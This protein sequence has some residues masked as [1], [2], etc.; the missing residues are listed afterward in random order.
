MFNTIKR[1]FNKINDFDVVDVESYSKRLSGFDR[2]VTF[3][4]R[5]KRIR[6]GK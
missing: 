2:S 1:L 6:D 3:A 4:D 5:V